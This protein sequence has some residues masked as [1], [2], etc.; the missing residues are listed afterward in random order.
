MTSSEIQMARISEQEPFVD[1]GDTMLNSGVNSKIYKE[2]IKSGFGLLGTFCLIA[3]FIVVQFGAVFTDYFVSE[4]AND[5]QII[6][7]QKMDLNISNKSLNNSFSNEALNTYI[8]N[9][10]YY[11]YRYIIQAN[12]VLLLLFTRPLIYYMMCVKA[13][14]RMF[15]KL[16]WAVLSKNLNFF[17]KNKE[18]DIMNRCSRDQGV[19]D[20]T[21]PSTNFDF[22]QI[23]SFIL[24]TFGLAIYVNYFILIALLPLCV[25]FY[26]FRK[27]YIEKARQLRRLEAE[28]RTPLLNHLNDT[29]SGIAVIRSS[30]KTDTYRSSYHSKMNDY[31]NVNFPYITAKRWF[32]LRL[33]LAIVIFIAFII[34]GSVLVQNWFKNLPI[35]PASIGLLL[36]Y[37]FQLSTQFQFCVRQSCEAECSMISVERICKYFEEEENDKQ[38]KTTTNITNW[39]SNGKIEL[40]NVSFRYNQQV[41]YIFQNKDFV[42]ESGQHFGII[43]FNGVGKSSLF[44]I[45][46]RL[47]DIENGNILIDN[48][49]IRQISLNDLRKRITII[50]QD[51]VIFQTTVRENLD[52]F[53]LKR[54]DELKRVLESV[55]L[56]RLD[57]DD[58]APNL[59]HGEKQLLCFA[60]G[61]L[62]DTKIYLIDE[63]TSNLSNEVER[64]IQ[65]IISE[66]LQNKTVLI[67]AH[68]VSTINK[69][70]KILEVH[71]KNKFYFDTPDELRNKPDSLLN[72]FENRDATKVESF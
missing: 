62:K 12:I 45:I 10:S 34:Y 17:L 41:G 54:D 43:G 60:R 24:I 16:L 72:I 8:P 2:Y 65:R 52:P 37:C 9:R 13:A 49:N 48:I 29:T 61:L 67:I 64:T 51:P 36:T 40:Q 22:I 33:D 47:Y 27:Y 4:W 63:A 38:G 44:N 39:P 71:G 19:V 66:T 1:N 11:L 55:D 35:T 21:L 31:T 28:K 58:Q 5:E 32:A 42:F 57:L 3:F 69:C 15:N 14:K 23:S 18:G 53:H 50:A 6:S 59:S 30:K 56:Q 70:N 20:E 25:F 46:L 26:C 68:R 7:L